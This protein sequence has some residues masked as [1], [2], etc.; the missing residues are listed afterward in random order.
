MSSNLSPPLRVG[1]AHAGF[2]QQNLLYAQAVDAIKKKTSEVYP[3][4][5]VNDWKKSFCYNN[6]F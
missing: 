2:Q 5:G 1:T 6:S 3:N 4:P